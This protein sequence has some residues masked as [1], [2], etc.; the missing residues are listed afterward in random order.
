MIPDQWYPVIESRRLARG[1]VLGLVRLGQSLVL[2]RDPSGDIV[3]MPDR[4]PHRAARLSRGRIR[5]GCLQCPYHGLF[6]NP[7]GKCVKVPVNGGDA[8]IPEG[9]DVT[10]LPAREG[11]G[12]VWIWNGTTRASYPPLPWLEP[13]S[14]ENGSTFTTSTELDVSYLRVME[15][16]GDF[17]HLPFVHRTTLPG[18]GT[19]MVDFDAREE[20]GIVKISG[21]LRP[22]RSHGPSWRDYRLRGELR[23]PAIA[24]VL[25]APR[26][27]LIVTVTPIDRDRCWAFLRYSQGYLPRW[28]GGRMLA[29]IA[30]WFDLNVVFRRQDLPTLKSQQLDDPADISSYRLLHAD[31]ASALYFGMRKR[32]IQ[33][34]LARSGEAATARRVQ[35]VL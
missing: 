27:S 35:R 1:R 18:A 20:N 7:Q 34:A 24:R 6:F 16:M 10:P 23:L 3:C 32:A 5:N 14:W 25:E 4:C 2:W 17:F 13:E 9:L 19:R 12:L 30:A 22:E 8:P 26:L 15:N 33:Q 11:Q 29:R 21:T 31:R 28:L